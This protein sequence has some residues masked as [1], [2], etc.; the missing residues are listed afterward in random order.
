MM[1]NWGSRAISGTTNFL[2]TFFICCAAIVVF[3]FLIVLSKGC[4]SKYKP[5][6]TSSQGQGVAGQTNDLGTD[7]GRETNAEEKGE[8]S[9]T[10]GSPA[11]SSQKEESSGQEAGKEGG[12][13]SE[14]VEAS[15]SNNG[16]QQAGQSN[17]TVQTGK[18]GAVDSSSKAGSPEPSDKDVSVRSTNQDIVEAVGNPR[19]PQPT[20]QSQGPSW[21]WDACRKLGVIENDIGR[22]QSSSGS[23]DT[24]YWRIYA[25][26]RN[27]AKIT[28]L[29]AS[30]TSIATNAVDKI[31]QS[32]NLLKNVEKWK[33]E[34]SLY[35]ESES[36]LM[37][38]VIAE[39]A[40][41]MIPK[42]QVHSSPELKRIEDTKGLKHLDAYTQGNYDGQAA[43]LES[44]CRSFLLLAEISDADKSY[45]LR[46]QAGREAL[47]K[48]RQSTIISRNEFIL[49][50]FC[51]A[52][53]I[54]ILSLDSSVLVRNEIQA[55]NHEIAR[56]L[57]QAQD[58]FS[59]VG[60]Q[61]EALSR[62]VHLNAKTLS[63][64]VK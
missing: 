29:M 62:L 47:A 15:G 31:S 43:W 64:A 63:K 34:D 21:S 52:V 61:A 5:L 60:C 35:L 30:Q 10:S 28:V 50:Q 48:P 36:S 56:N 33:P 58:P 51:A 6:Q 55:I 23:P 1:G 41:L 19:P 40:F 59:K 17:A 49:N 46:I 27:V 38:C 8:G 13:E 16:G 3:V 22:K 42:N 37:S 24:V 7:G 20:K 9:G 2:V 18:A 4:E 11:A 32:R 25:S 44:A 54:G 39:C 12:S 14:K 53:E 45:A 57:T 26:L